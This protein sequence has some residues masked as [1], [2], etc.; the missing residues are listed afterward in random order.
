[1][2]IAYATTRKEPWV[3][4]G[5]ARAVRV[6]LSRDEYEWLERTA[7]VVFNRPGAPASDLLR[8]LVLSAQQQLGA[9]HTPV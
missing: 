2:A 5:I 8:A 1:V 3:Q 7:A 4:D 6:E 9:Q